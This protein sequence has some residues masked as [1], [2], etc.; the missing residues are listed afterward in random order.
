MTELKH[1]VQKLNETLR[2]YIQR[3]TALHPTVENVSEH[4]A[5]C[6][7]KE[8]VWYRDL[9]LKFDRTGDMTLARMMEIATQYTNGEDEDRLHSGKKTNQSPK[10]SEEEI[11]VGR[12]NARLKLQVLLKLQL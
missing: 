2:D 4:Q 8:G 7:F 1:C 10:T 6:T 12:R 3:W 5:V 11:P 9:N